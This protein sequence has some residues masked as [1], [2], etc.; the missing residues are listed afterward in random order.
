MAAVSQGVRPGDA[1]VF[2]SERVFET[3]RPSAPV[4]VLW[5]CA[6]GALA[7]FRSCRCSAPWHRGTCLGAGAEILIAA[8]ARG[9]VFCFSI[10]LSPWTPG[11][12]RQISEPSH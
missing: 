12:A 9:D 4:D 2:P 6:T 5:F 1:I 11:T 10:P 7:W 3:G 8:P